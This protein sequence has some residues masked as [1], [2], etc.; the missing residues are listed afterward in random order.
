MNSNPTEASPEIVKEGF[1]KVTTQTLGVANE[2]VRDLAGYVLNSEEINTAVVKFLMMYDIDS[3]DICSV[4]VGSTK[5]GELKIIAEV[6]AKA[7]K[8]KKKSQNNWMDFD[9]D[10]DERIDIPDVLYSAWNNKF[11]HGKRKNLKIMKIKR[12]HENYLAINIDPQ[13]FLAFVYDIN[14]CDPLYKISAPQRRW[15][16]NKELDDMSGKQRKR[17]KLEQQQYSNY[18]ITRC[19]VFITFTDGYTFK[20]RKNDGTV[21]EIVG[22]HP[23]EVDAYYENRK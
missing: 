11:Y 4:K 12:D 10:Y 9:Q 21:E 2:R 14:F 1:P 22:F 3:D 6:R 15:K 16:S 19:G 5:D 20:L 17:Y 13:I 18:G 23:A 7:L 8:V